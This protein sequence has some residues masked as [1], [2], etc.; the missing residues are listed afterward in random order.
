MADISKEPNDKTT[1]VSRCQNV[2]VRS[3][4]G[5]EGLAQLCHNILVDRT[6]NPTGWLSTIFFKSLDRSERS[7]GGMHT[8]MEFL[9]SARKTA[10][11]ELV[12]K[13]AVCM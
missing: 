4:V 7:K 3:Y 12:L 1:E 10:H 11:I 6:T 5:K 2:H 13:G 9:V 8:C